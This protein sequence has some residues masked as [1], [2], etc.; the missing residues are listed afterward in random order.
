VLA[1]S[2]AITPKCFGIPIAAFTLQ[3]ETTLRTRV[4]D[5]S[6]SNQEKF[7]WPF[8]IFWLTYF[9]IISGLVAFFANLYRF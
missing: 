2:I 7:N 9:S 4:P 8:L 3:M 1:D 5:R 6:F